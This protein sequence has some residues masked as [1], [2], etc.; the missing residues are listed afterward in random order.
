VTGRT[1]IRCPE[2]LC[3]ITRQGKHRLVGMSWLCL[4]AKWAEKLREKDQHM[5]CV[6][7]PFQRTTSISQSFSG[8]MHWW[9]GSAWDFSHEIE[10]CKECSLSR[11]QQ[12]HGV[13]LLGPFQRILSELLP[14]TRFHSI[15]QYLAGRVDVSSWTQEHL[16]N[17]NATFAE[18]KHQ[19]YW[20]Q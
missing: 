17:P 12:N 9:R 13:F 5:P 15:R 8:S 7:E 19:N 2:V 16:D 1:R 6:Q 4:E 14:I 10:Q 3:V 11:D 20:F 18:S